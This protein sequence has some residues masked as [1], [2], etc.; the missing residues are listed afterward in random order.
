MHS[1]KIKYIANNQEYWL[2]KICYNQRPLA[3]EP[4]GHI[5]RCASTTTATLH[6]KKKHRINQ[7][8]F[9]P[10]NSPTNTQQ[11]IDSFDSLIRERNTAISQF[12][13]ATFKALLIRLFTVE[14]LALVKVESQAFRDLLIY[15]QLD[16]RG[17]IP[18]RRSLTRYIG[19]A[20]EKSLSDVEVALI[21]AKTRINLSFDLWTSLGRCLSLLGVVAHY[22]DAQWKPMIV[23]LAL[24]RMYS[25]HTGVSITKQI[26]EILTHFRIAN[27]FGHTI[28]DNA[29]ENTACLDHLSELLGI[30]L[31]SHCVMCIGHVINLVAQECL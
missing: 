6:L 4:I 16:L 9:M 11:T 17:S 27:N 13:L 2:C 5:Y 14:Q 23:L 26:Y 12:D 20:Y 10:A 15:L 3:R 18:S 7:H 28:A 21:G 1:F 30:T 8:G 25:R 31:D 24:L 29:S 22:L 19:Y